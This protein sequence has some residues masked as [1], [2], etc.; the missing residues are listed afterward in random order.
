MPFTTQHIRIG[1]TFGSINGT[2]RYVLSY[3]DFAIGQSRRICSRQWN[4]LAAHATHTLRIPNQRTSLARQNGQRLVVVNGVSARTSIVATGP[5]FRR[6][7]L[8]DARDVNLHAIWS[9][10][11][12]VEPRHSDNRMLRVVLESED[13]YTLSEVPLDGEDAAQNHLFYWRD[14][15][16][17]SYCVTVQVY[18][19]TG[20]RD[21]TS[22]GDIH[23]LPQKR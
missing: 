18:S 1:S 19:A 22:I 16:P 17:G 8:S 2:R 7:L 20:A 6:T 23:A 5:L 15:P 10:A 13:Y 21:F 3:A 4:T 9:H 11:T 12:G 14:L